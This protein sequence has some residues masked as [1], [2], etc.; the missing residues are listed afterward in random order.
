LTES[1]TQ[2]DAPRRGTISCAHAM[3]TQEFLRRLGVSR[4]EGL[5]S[6]EAEERIRYYGPN[7]IE[8]HPPKSAWKV[9]DEQFRGLVV[10]LL[11]A[12]TVVS[13]FFGEIAEAS[14]IMVVLGPNATIGFFT[15]MRAVRSMEALRQI[16]QQRR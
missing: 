3:T 2:A 9:L 5:S 10:W 13:F 12:A 14:A 16:R 15:E 1:S 7:A 6:V 4:E 8:D 11:V